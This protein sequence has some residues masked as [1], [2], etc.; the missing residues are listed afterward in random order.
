[1]AIE[2][3]FWMFAFVLAFLSTV[4]G[5]YNDEYA[6]EE[7]YADEDYYDDD[8]AQSAESDAAMVGYDEDGAG[9]VTVSTWTL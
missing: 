4:Y 6:Y 2:R 1:M 3:T 7:A 8:A 9:F 5:A